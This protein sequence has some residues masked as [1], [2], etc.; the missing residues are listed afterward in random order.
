V[1]Y[2]AGRVH[3]LDQAF[4][5]ASRYLRKG[6][7]LDGAVDRGLADPAGADVITQRLAG[8]AQRGDDERARVRCEQRLRPGRGQQLVDRRDL[9]Q[10]ALPLVH[11]RSSIRKTSAE[12]TAR[13]TRDE[14]RNLTARGHGRKMR[15]MAPANAE[16]IAR[17]I[18]A[19]L[20]EAGHV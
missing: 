1:Q 13:G 8:A 2:D 12:T 3:D 18:V 20:R 10:A 16:S 14:K 7:L 9:P 4:L 11:E 5:G 19:R 17:A 6:A 15:C